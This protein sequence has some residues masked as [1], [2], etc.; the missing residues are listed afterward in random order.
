M[1]GG[2]ARAVATAALALLAAALAAGLAGTPALAHGTAADEYGGV[3]DFA[4][5]LPVAGQP[6]AVALR[7]FYADRDPVDGA[8][9][10]LEVGNTPVA[11]TLAPGG[12]PG[13]YVGR[14]V[15]PAAK[16]YRLLVHVQHQGLRLYAD[17]AMRVLR[18]PGEYGGALA[19]QGRG[20][21]F[22]PA[23]SRKPAT[24]TDAVTWQVMLAGVPLVA[25][26][27]WWGRRGAAPAGARAAAGAIVGSAGALPRPVGGGGAGAAP[28]VPAWI[29]T[30]ALLGGFAQQAGGYWDIA[31][32]IARG[33]E[34]FW[35]PPH[36][37]IYG[38]ILTALLAVA[39]G[40]LWDG[41]ARR[42]VWGRG[43]LAAVR[44]R[45]RQH[46]GLALALWSMVAQ[47]SSAPFD[48]LWHR[49]FG[50]DVSVW[51]PPHLL[52][53]FGGTFA[54]VG[55]A[56]VQAGAV[57]P[58]RRDGAWWRTAGFAAAAFGIASAFLAEFEFA[59]R[60]P[61]WHISQSRPPA[62]YPVLLAL[63]LVLTA[64]VAVRLGGPGAATAATALAWAYRAGIIWGLLPALGQLQPRPL[65]LA[66]LP[67]A[68]ALD[69]LAAVP[70]RRVPAV[71]G[72]NPALAG[73]LRHALAGGLAALTLLALYAPLAA[74][75]PAAAA[76]VPDLV[77]WAP[78][79]LVVCTAGGYVAAHVGA[80]WPQ[81]GQER[82]PGVAAAPL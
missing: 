25:L 57:Q 36:L 56:A 49:T 37:L 21:W 23:G 12:Q 71:A 16:D 33:R 75:L 30:L 80:P 7:L 45:L 38:G 47:L 82:W 72:G 63:F 19:V 53:I 18:Q 44:Q 78:V 32:H 43:G 81:A 41:E 60:I 9:V 68:A 70:W 48:E 22:R 59:S 74:L 24:W 66:L 51:S 3:V 46:P 65:P 54:Y 1:T 77:V 39:A 2:F 27:L 8:Q 52:L 20:L 14:F 29:L 34:S 35:Q 31:F 5:A 79:A 73:S 11:V 64:G 76:P 62:L 6:V 50:L 10:T 67:A 40:L 15:A 42:P 55:L 58:G 61:L 28:A 17:S 13:L 4:P 69:L 26:G